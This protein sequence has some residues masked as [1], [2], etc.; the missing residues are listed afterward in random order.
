MKSGLYWCYSVIENGDLLAAGLITA[1]D[2]DRQASADAH[3]AITE[4]ANMPTD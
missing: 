1:D 3:G 4:R 2:F